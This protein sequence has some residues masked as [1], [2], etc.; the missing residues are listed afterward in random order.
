MVL[1]KYDVMK[2]WCNETVQKQSAKSR[3]FVKQYKNSKQK[4][5]KARNEEN[6][7]RREE[8]KKGEGLQTHSIPPVSEYLL[9]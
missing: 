4:Q 3:D 9:A 5:K 8:N 2:T 7:E 6:E 1:G